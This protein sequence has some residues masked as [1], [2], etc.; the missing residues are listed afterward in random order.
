MFSLSELVIALL[1]KERSS[2][3]YV[4]KL[5]KVRIREEEHLYVILDLVSRLGMHTGCR[6]CQCSAVHPSHRL[7]AVAS[8][9]H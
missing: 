3:F 1:G 9:L 8:G 4:L 2:T 5:S 6:R 7:Y